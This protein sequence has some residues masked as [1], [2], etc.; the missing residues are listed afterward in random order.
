MASAVNAKQGAQKAS[1]VKRA[2]TFFQE[3][4]AELLK[5]RWPSREELTKFTAV[6]LVA[7]IAVAVYIGIVDGIFSWLS[8]AIGMGPK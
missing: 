5:A 6:V 8:A 7:V 4:W 2:K 1:V 3:V